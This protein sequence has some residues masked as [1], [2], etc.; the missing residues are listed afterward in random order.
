MT[1][2]GVT[3]WVLSHLMRDEDGKIHRNSDNKVQCGVSGADGV[4][5][6]QHTCSLAEDKQY[7]PY[8]KHLKNAHDLDFYDE[9]LK[10]EAEEKIKN[11]NAWAKKTRT[12]RKD[13]TYVKDFSG[14]IDW[15]ISHGIPYS[16]FED[17]RWRKICEG[18]VGYAKPANKRQFTDALD[19]CADAKRNAL[20][21]SLQTRDVS[22]SADG[23]MTCQRPTMGVTATNRTP[24]Q[25]I[26]K[27]LAISECKGK[28]P[29]D[30]VKVLDVA[31][32]QLTFTSGRLLSLCSDNAANIVVACRKICLARRMIFT[33]CCIHSLQLEMFRTV[34]T[35]DC[36][37]SMAICQAS[38]L[39]RAPVV[40]RWWSFYASL[41]KVAKVPETEVNG[42][43]L[44]NRLAVTKTLKGLAMYRV[45]GRLMEQ[46]ACT[47]PGSMRLWIM[48]IKNSSGDLAL[49]LRDRLMR[50]M[51]G[52][53]VCAAILSPKLKWGT[54]DTKGLPT[55]V[56]DCP[57]FKDRRSLIETL[58]ILHSKT[59]TGIDVIIRE[60]D[61]MQTGEEQRRC[62]PK[63]LETYDYYGADRVM[64][65]PA[66]CSASRNML[67]DKNHEGC[68]ERVFSEMALSHTAIRN[69]TSADHIEAEI[70]IRANS[71]LKFWMSADPKERVSVPDA[72][73]PQIDRLEEDTV[74]MNG[75][76]HMQEVKLF[77]GWNHMGSMEHDDC[78]TVLDL[79]KRILRF[80]QLTKMEKHFVKGLKIEYPGPSCTIGAY[81]KKLTIQGQYGLWLSN[82]A[83]EKDEK[84]WTYIALADPKLTL[85]A[86]K[87]L[88]LLDGR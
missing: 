30:L 63:D 49:R 23:G 16:A 15:A 55:F 25:T 60:L 71:D 77:E 5:Q 8:S 65:V 83:G 35:E 54:E 34:D 58:Q 67:K 59:G 43:S 42:L 85:W 1:A 62:E 39:W 37:A 48:L 9:K 41:L 22:V 38:S 50:M 6:C 47:I 14:F 36:K 64:I 68:V 32:N 76:A 18:H 86:V 4:G 3:A 27:P 46:D 21:Q 52:I 12:V 26:C 33:R 11:S 24:L 28:E 84:K 61:V 44:E 17:R 53:H 20:I 7:G 13:E 72:E 57:A 79:Y 51:D 70:I 78:M 73:P 29:A 88:D 10:E 19:A 82:S 2:K 56:R 74:I 40:T 81:V 80:F 75:D 66:V 69:A 87:N 31:L 45:A